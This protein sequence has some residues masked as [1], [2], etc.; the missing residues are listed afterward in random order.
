M[1]GRRVT[2]GVTLLVLLAVLGGMGVFGYRALTSPL[3]G[4]QAKDKTCSS[5][6]KVVK[7]VLNRSEVQV[8]VFNAGTKEGLASTTLDKVEAAGF[9]AGNAG[10]APKSAEIRRAIVWTTKPDD[11]AAKLVAQAFGA[12]TRVEVTDTD[13]GPGV[14]VLVGNRFQG[15]D[16]K[17][18]RRI[19]LAAPLATCV[20]VG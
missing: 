12:R 19:R 6:E 10:N 20:P 9:K 14:D 1:T 15:L 13:L 2:T 3:P 8:S 18:P 5:V 4:G 16:P 17:A 11:P 7:K